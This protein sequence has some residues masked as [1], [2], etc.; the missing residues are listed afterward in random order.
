[1]SNDNSM[2]KWVARVARFDDET[3]SSDDDPEPRITSILV[4]MREPKGSWEQAG[5]IRVK[6]SRPGPAVADDVVSMVS[7]MTEEQPKL[8]I[9]LRAY[10]GQVYRAGKTWPW[11][12]PA[13]PPREDP[14]TAES[15]ALVRELRT[16][17]IEQGSQLVKI[18]AAGWQ[19]AD[20]LLENQVR[21]TDEIANLRKQLSEQQQT[22]GF[23]QLTKELAPMA[24]VVVA[25]VVERLTAPSPAPPVAHPPALEERPTEN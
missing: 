20:R 4:E 7:E 13:A 8:S 10:A 14:I 17:V 22:D 12:E 16:L 1:V 25:A 6:G 18:G 3:E 15:A 21:L 9:R 11:S 24:P 19:T 2:W 23:A 5:R